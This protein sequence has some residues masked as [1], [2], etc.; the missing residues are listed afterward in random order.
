MNKK[1]TSIVAIIAA[2]SVIV[3][4]NI[5]SMSKTSDEKYVI[6][7]WESTYI[8]STGQKVKDNKI[9][10]SNSYWEGGKFSF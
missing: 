3:I 1:I 2:L 9:H 7:K 6:K 4:T 8:N 10:L 5:D